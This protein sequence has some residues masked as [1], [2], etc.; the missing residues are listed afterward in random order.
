[1]YAILI[2]KF[3]LFFIQTITKTFRNRSGFPNI[4][5]APLLYTV[6]N[7]DNLMNY[8]HTR[9]QDNC[10]YGKMIKLVYNI[11]ILYWK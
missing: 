7:Y 8:N 3:I 1:M 6:M 2:L 10:M 4:S 5:N 9:D 11:I